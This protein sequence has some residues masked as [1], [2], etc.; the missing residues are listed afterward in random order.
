VLFRESESDLCCGDAFLGALVI[1]R[2]YMFN[3]LFPC[4]CYTE[5]SALAPF[6]AIFWVASGMN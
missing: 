3:L 1:C 6:A 2:S 4:P 5:P